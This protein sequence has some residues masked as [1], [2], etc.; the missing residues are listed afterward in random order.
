M[1]CAE[2][3]PVGTRVQVQ[4]THGALYFPPCSL[5]P[6]SFQF[7]IGFSRFADKDLLLFHLVVTISFLF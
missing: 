1:R 7:V 5:L 4:L 6:L 3:K 2:R